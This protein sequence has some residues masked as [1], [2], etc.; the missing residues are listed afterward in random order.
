[1]D[2]SLPNKTEIQKSVARFE[3]DV[4][5]LLQFYSKSF[6]EILSKYRN[7]NCHSAFI[8]WLLNDK[9]SHGLGKFGIKK[10]LEIIFLRGQERICQRYPELA[11]YFNLKVV[12]T[13]VEKVTKEKEIGKAGMLDIYAE[14]MLAL[15]K[16]EYTLKLIVENKVESVET[17]K[18][19]K[20]QTERYF[21]HFEK[22]EP[23]SKKGKNRVKKKEIILYVYLTPQPTLELNQP[24]E[25]KCSCKEFIN[26]NYQDLVDHLLEPALLET[27]PVTGRT[28]LII[29]EYI[30]SLSFSLNEHGQ[31]KKSNIFMMANNSEE[32]KLLSDFWKTHRELIIAASKAISEDSHII[33]KELR[34]EALAVA[35]S[36]V[37]KEK[38][39]V[40]V[41]NKLTTMFLNGAIE[42]PEVE[43]MK[44]AEYSKEVF[45][46][47]QPL[48]IEAKSKE[49]LKHYYKKPV[50]IGNMDYFICQEWAKSKRKF[51]ENWLLKKG[52]K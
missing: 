39:G 51:F 41:L 15:N 10:F 16:D 19:G 42:M 46:I 7:E 52:E 14:V 47:Y 32:R 29:R 37:K 2:E 20:Y 27:E 13:N 23:K 24:L 25:Q 38:V 31:T 43:R 1:M 8:A 12:I 48:L 30:R 35:S 49:K 6:S 21:S 18:D 9:E 45:G 28:K 40:Y 26:I 50:K 34:N 44:T 33:E 11:D 5:K 17:I 3:E 22:Q 4:P 36:E